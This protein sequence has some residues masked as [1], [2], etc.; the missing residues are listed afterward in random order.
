MEKEMVLSREITELI[1]K[2]DIEMLRVVESKFDDLMLGHSE[3][4]MKNFIVEQFLTPDRKH[5]QC[6]TELWARYNALVGS[7]YERGKLKLQ[8]ERLK[9]RRKN[10]MINSSWFPIIQPKM[11]SLTP[12]DEIELGEIELDITYTKIKLSMISR[13]VE[14]TLREM[15][16]FFQT[17]NDL[18]SKRVFDNYEEAEEEY[19]RLKI[20]L[21]N[22][23]KVP[24]PHICSQSKGK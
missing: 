9:L 6:L 12:E 14:E 3:Y 18:E 22:P 8:L 4:Q 17:Y 16:F 7:W 1:A 24:M 13:T 19:W 2:E 5:R 11:K 15:K 20:R 21:D 10:M 23:S